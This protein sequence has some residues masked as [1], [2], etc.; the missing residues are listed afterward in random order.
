MGVAGPVCFLGRQ[1]GRLPL[2]VLCTKNRP[3]SGNVS[4]SGGVAVLFLCRFNPPTRAHQLHCSLFA[5]L[6]FKSLPTYLPPPKV[7]PAGPPSEKLELQPRSNC[8]FQTKTTTK[9]EL[10]GSVRFRRCLKTVIAEIQMKDIS[11][12]GRP[13]ENCGKR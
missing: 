13:V 1:E 6:A 12:R 5:I 3:K 8:D 4:P 10:A 9:L 2:Q 11:G 7:I